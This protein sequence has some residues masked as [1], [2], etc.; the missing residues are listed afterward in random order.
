MFKGQF[1]GTILLGT[2]LSLTIGLTIPSASTGAQGLRPPSEWT[3]SNPATQA[4]IEAQLERH[5]GETLTFVAYG[6]TGQKASREGILIPLEK[7]FGIHFLED[8]QPDSAKIEAMVN[9]G[10]VTWDVV[11]LG[12]F[13]IWNLGERGYL[14]ALDHRI[15]DTRGL[16][17]GVVTRWSAGG[18]TFLWGTVLAYRRG[19]RQPHSWADFWNTKDF[20]GR[21][22][23]GDFL[24]G[25]L[26]IALFAAGLSPAQ[27]AF[28]LT[29]EREELTFRKLEE[30]AP[31]VNVYWDSGSQCP[32]LLINGELDYCSAWNGRIYDAQK[33]GAP[34]EMCWECGWV[35]G[36][37]GDVIPRG[38][39]H[40][41]LAQLVIAWGSFL[42]N[43][44]QHSNYITYA[45]AVDPSALPRAMQ[46][47]QKTLDPTTLAALS[48]S[49]SNR[50]YML[51]ADEKW[52]GENFDR[53][54]GRYQAI[55]S[56][57]R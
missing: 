50:P 9:S 3:L 36:S 4:E 47:L 18:D 30:L 19:V 42:P 31:S 10:N 28:P 48:G 37:N 46:L 41:E 53:L 29:R 39:R 22:G 43:V 35:A 20:P 57:H 7:R 55:F 45:P 27:I 5:R 40:T 12:T 15:V 34:I 14:Q 1:G 25:H 13:E 44:I 51:L 52:E 49:E 24:T 54:N 33:A 8:T 17:K 26:E 2:L 38:S 32:Q 6:G 11:S 16:L 56:Q 23:Y 21:R